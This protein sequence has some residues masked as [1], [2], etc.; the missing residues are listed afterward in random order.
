MKMVSKG[1]WTEDE[2]FIEALKW[3][4]YRI[5]NSFMKSSFFIE[6]DEDEIKEKFSGIM[7]HHSVKPTKLHGPLY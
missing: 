4:I 5:L 6:K 7:L 3:L 1:A 2:S